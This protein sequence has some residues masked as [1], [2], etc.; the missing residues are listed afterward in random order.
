MPSALE[1][2]VIHTKMKSLYK[3]RNTATHK[4]TV[5]LHRGGTLRKRNM[6]GK[7]LDEDADMIFIPAA[8]LA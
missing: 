1:L 2:R 6:D 3:Q 8:Q 4:Y 7:L 5:T